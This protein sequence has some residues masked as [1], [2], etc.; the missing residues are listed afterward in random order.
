MCSQEHQIPSLF[1]WEVEQP[2]SAHRGRKWRIISA[3]EITY[4]NKLSWHLRQSIPLTL[5]SETRWRKSSET[6][7]R[8]PLCSH[9]FSEC[10]KAAHLAWHLYPT[11]TGPKG[12]THADRKLKS[13]ALYIHVYLLCWT[14]LVRDSPLN[15]HYFHAPMRNQ[16]S[17][18]RSIFVSNI[19]FFFVIWW[20]L[21]P[22]STIF[23]TKMKQTQVTSF[24]DI[25]QASHSSLWRHVCKFSVCGLSCRQL[26]YVKPLCKLP[27]QH[28]TTDPAERADDRIHTCFIIACSSWR[29]CA[30]TKTRRG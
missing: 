8:L 14:C 9:M 6:A 19:L 5:Y 24:D 12:C 29:Q 22:N 26:F 3:E 4:H 15:V 10:L 16:Y 17:R 25:Y 13:P 7:E 2:C 1:R 28:Q 21:R 27:A 20:L 30:D 18:S 23:C 11:P